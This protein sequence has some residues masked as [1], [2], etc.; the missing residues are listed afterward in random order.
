MM[1]TVVC[2]EDDREGDNKSEAIKNLCVGAD[3]PDFLVQFY[4]NK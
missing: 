3:S 1:T 4:R 2:E